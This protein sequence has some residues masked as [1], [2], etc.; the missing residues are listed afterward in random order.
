MQE[1]ISVENCEG[2]SLQVV[3]TLAGSDIDIITGTDEHV[4]TGRKPVNESPN[5]STE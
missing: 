1:P 4:N 3:E 5:K 2:H